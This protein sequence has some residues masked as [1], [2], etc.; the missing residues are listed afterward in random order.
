MTD[1][2]DL[3]L[4]HDRQHGTTAKE[5]APV[6]R[7]LPKLMRPVVFTCSQS[8]IFII[9]RRMGRMAFVLR[10]SKCHGLSVQ[11]YRVLADL[12]AVPAQL[13]S[14]Y[15]KSRWLS[16]T[17]LSTIARLPSGSSASRSGAFRDGALSVGAGT[18]HGCT[19]RSVASTQAQRRCRASSLP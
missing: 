14:Q 9:Y 12:W 17:T 3:K 16:R 7:P 19:R 13:C 2:I 11:Q 18:A 5:H 10:N 4:Y 15:G 1:F 8:T 6:F